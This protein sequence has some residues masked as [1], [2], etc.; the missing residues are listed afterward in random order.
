MA[1]GA[2]IAGGIFAPLVDAAT[3]ARAV[4]WA[5]KTPH[6]SPDPVMV[7]LD[8]DAV[9][10]DQIDNPDGERHFLHRMQMPATSADFRLQPGNEAFLQPLNC[11]EAGACDHCGCIQ[12]CCRITGLSVNFLVQKVQIFYK[13]HVYLYKMALKP[14]A[15]NVMQRLNPGRTADRY[16][17]EFS[18][19]DALGVIDFLK[20]NNG[21]HPPKCVTRET[22]PP[23]MRV[24][25]DERHHH[26]HFHGLLQP[27][28]C[29]PGEHF[30]L[31]AYGEAAMGVGDGWTD[32][33]YFIQASA[34]P[35]DILTFELPP[36]V[37][38]VVKAMVRGLQ[39]LLTLYV[40][41]A[42][43]EPL[44]AHGCDLFELS[45]CIVT[46]C[47]APAEL[48]EEPE[49]PTSATVCP[50]LARFLLAALQKFY[51]DAM[52]AT[53]TII[54]NAVS[55]GLGVDVTEVER[56]IGLGAPLSENDA[57]PRTLVLYGNIVPYAIEFP[58]HDD[59]L[60]LN[61]DVDL[62]LT[63][64]D[65]SPLPD[66]LGFSWN[67]LED[68]KN[69]AVVAQTIDHKPEH[70]SKLPLRRTLNRI[71]KSCKLDEVEVEV[72]LHDIG[73]V[74]ARHTWSSVLEFT[75][76]ACSVATVPELEAI[77]GL[78]GSGRVR[79]PRDDR[80][81][82]RAANTFQR[83]GSSVVVSSAASVVAV[84]RSDPDK[85]N[86]FE[87]LQ[88]LM[89]D[90]VI[91]DFVTAYLSCKLRLEMAS[92]GAGPEVY[93]L[94]LA[95]RA[96]MRFPTAD[97]EVET[98]LAEIVP[99]AILPPLPHHTVHICIVDLHREDI[100]HSLGVALA[101]LIKEGI[102]IARA[103]VGLRSSFMVWFVDD[104]S[105]FDLASAILRENCSA[106]PV[107]D[108]KSWAE[109]VVKFGS[110]C[111]AKAGLM[112]PSPTSLA[113]QDRK[114][115]RLLLLSWNRTLHDHGV[116]IAEEILFNSEAAID[117]AVI[118]NVK[119]SGLESAVPC[120]VD[121]MEK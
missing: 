34:E 74:L 18:A 33:P 9:R 103:V 21:F 70:N 51:I 35:H 62:F 26:Q 4:E 40:E 17:A 109:R 99:G 65:P 52:K 5:R 86:E 27:L 75:E 54:M 36:P 7:L 69:G 94:P 2:S 72:P 56:E 108:A 118:S 60:K 1:G 100:G 15:I 105:S 81:I 88:A 12:K 114:K 11:E 16:E 24:Y 121:L 116:K 84:I 92:A 117:S 55:R 49:L 53:G 83:Q 87:Q 29:P 13:A 97:D 32:C 80:K 50:S 77:L 93:S 102:H 3:V 14:L 90:H 78:T 28:P 31:L 66:P 79:I 85:I 45:S 82:T 63:D 43:R 110:T 25:I 106:L 98:N 23:G 89:E 46:L 44:R 37:S 67:R 119:M 47:E 76:K 48:F 38:P 120:I 64:A 6:A 91:A 71:F 41:V 111:F 42:V 101:M 95:T 30:S 112:S 73:E 96:L 58:Q 22:P 39:Q 8:K 107:E 68:L 61:R 115:K 20:A 113:A 104:I 19:M 10:K 59:S 57:K